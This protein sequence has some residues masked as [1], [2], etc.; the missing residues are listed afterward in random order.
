[1]KD[2]HYCMKLAHLLNRLRYGPRGATTS[3]AGEGM[4]ALS[5]FFARRGPVDGSLSAA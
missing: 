2:W 3:G 5:D 4:R 1:M